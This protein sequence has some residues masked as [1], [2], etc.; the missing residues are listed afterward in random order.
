MQLYGYVTLLQIPRSG[1]TKTPFDFTMF[2]MDGEWQVKDII[3]DKEYMIQSGFSE[4]NMEGS[5]Q[6]NRFMPRHF[7]L[8]FENGER[9]KLQMPFMEEPFYGILDSA[10]GYPGEWHHYLWNENIMALLENK[11]NLYT[12]ENMEKCVNLSHMEIFVYNGYSILDW[13]ERA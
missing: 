6:D 9:L 7:P 13:L 2:W 10:C 8:P 12:R 4:K 11:R 1:K 3:V 5:D